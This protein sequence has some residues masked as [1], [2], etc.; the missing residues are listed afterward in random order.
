VFCSLGTIIVFLV[1]S[2]FANAVTDLI[3]KNLMYC[4]RSPNNSNQK[5]VKRIIA[6]EGDTVK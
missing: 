3:L 4:Y 5:L 2:L 1:L 6:V